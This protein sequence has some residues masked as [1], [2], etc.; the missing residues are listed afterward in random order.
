M[1]LRFSA[2]AKWLKVPNNLK[3]FHKKAK[4]AFSTVLTYPYGS[5]LPCFF[6]KRFLPDCQIEAK[7]FSLAAALLKSIIKIALTQSLL[8]AFLEYKGGF[9]A[10]AVVQE[11]FFNLILPTVP[12]YPVYPAKE[13]V[14]MWA[15]ALPFLW[16]DLAAPSES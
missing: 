16:C 12:Q 10:S 7:S 3:H 4:R 5:E 1:N 13:R 8:E 9:L 14:C 6:P 15:A 2:N 11:Y